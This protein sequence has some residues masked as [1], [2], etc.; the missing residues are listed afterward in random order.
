MFKNEFGI[1]I[2][3]VIAGIYAMLSIILLFRI[4]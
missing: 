1:M 3:D 4:F 2:D